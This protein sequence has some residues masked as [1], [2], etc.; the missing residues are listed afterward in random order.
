MLNTFLFLSII[1]IFTFLIGKVI[2]KIKVPWVFAALILGFLLAIYNPF[3]S[4]TASSEFNFLA[5]L[6]MYFLL[7]IIGFELNLKKI[8]EKSK[9]IFSATFFIIF[10]EA[11]FGSL[12]VHI[13]FNYPWLVSIL[14]ALSFATVGEAVLIPILDEFK[15]VTTRLGQVIVGIGCLDD[16]I[17]VFTLIF[18]VLLV[19]SNA[20]TQLDIGMVLGSLFTLFVLTIGFTKLKEEGIKFR[21]GSIETL[22]LFTT[23]IFFLFLGIGEYAESA[24][25]AALL[26]GIS[27]KTFIPEKR[28]ELIENEVKTMCYGFF[29][30]IFFLWVG[31]AMDISYIFAYPLLVLIVAV[32]SIGSKLL[33]SYIIGRKELG[34]KQS[35]L[36]GMGLCVRFS[37]S[38]VIIKILFDSGIIHNDIYSVILASTVL[39]TFFIPILFSNLVVRWREVI[40]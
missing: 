16:M 18:L 32:V 23:F 6:G 27:L 28:L 30:P 10:F 38:I 33:G 22:F 15:I 20:Y 31:A 40:Y 4:I 1:F 3:R 19:G 36:L 14:I 39:F 24:P 29:A 17:E 7:F 8:K 37:T 9:F 12:L 34:S 13:V 5:N 11:V 26:A 2:E 25:L 21:F 35:V